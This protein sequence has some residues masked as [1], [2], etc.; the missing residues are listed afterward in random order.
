MSGTI[1]SS[2]RLEAARRGDNQ[3]CEQVL[4]ENN[5]L[6]WS[7]VRRY[8]GRG[9]EPDDLYQLGCLGFLKAVQGYDPDFGTQFSTYAVPK[10]AGEIRRF[11]RDDGPMKV[12][13]G[14]KERGVSIRSARS[15]LASE[16]G[17]EPSL[18][19]LAQE[20]GLTPEEIAAAETAS[21]PVVSLQTETGDSGLT[22]EGMLTA[23]GEEEGLVER[24]ALRAAMAQLPQREQQVLLLRYYR[25]M[26]QVQ[27]ARIIGVSQVQVSRLE[28][29]ALE[30]LRK[31][32]TQ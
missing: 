9:V 20:T 13:R 25:G 1:S 7:V 21:E 18:S 6:I 12:S 4:Q 17:R 2:D 19:E 26:T 11:L 16:L 28:R 8:Y 31:D 27:T 3:A 23:G 30:Q 14:L 22:L 15:R 24:L 29:R 10:I 5:G 32:M